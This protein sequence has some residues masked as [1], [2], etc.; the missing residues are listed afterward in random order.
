ML[1]FVLFIVNAVTPE[2]S[3]LPTPKHRLEFLCTSRL[4]RGKLL[5]D[6]TQKFTKMPP[7]LN[8]SFKET[9][10][11]EGITSHCIVLCSYGY[12][13][14]FNVSSSFTHF[15]L[16]KLLCNE[17]VYSPLERLSIKSRF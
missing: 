17:P 12:K 11:Q 2:S 16:N 4:K 7:Y 13:L 15:S 9:R 1:E 14:A 6:S 5:L 8:L 10:S 3:P